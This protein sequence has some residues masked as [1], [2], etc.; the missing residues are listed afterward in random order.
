MSAAA[1]ATQPGGHRPPFAITLL[2]G[3]GLAPRRWDG[4]ART[5]TGPGQENNI[6]SPHLCLSAFLQAWVSI[7]STIPPLIIHQHA[8]GKLSGW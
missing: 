4:T 3:K 1:V 6:W 2:P 7:R 5:C 8:A